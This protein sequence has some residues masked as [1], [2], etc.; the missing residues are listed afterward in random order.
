[1]MVQPIEYSS[2]CKI[3]ELGLDDIILINGVK[4]WVDWVWDEGIAIISEQD[5]AITFKMDDIYSI[6]LIEE[7]WRQSNSRC[8]IVVP[9]IKIC[10]A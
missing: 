5:E 8:A 10:S 3:I 7:C 4:G 6:K 2:E 1:M 9:Y